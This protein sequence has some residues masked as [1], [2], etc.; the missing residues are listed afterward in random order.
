MMFPLFTVM[1]LA[2]DRKQYLRD[3]LNSVLLQSIDKSSFEILLIT[4]FPI[5]EEVS[6]IPN[7]KHM[8][9]DK[10]ELEIKIAEGIKQCRGEIVCFLEDDDTWEEDKLET[11]RRIFTNNSEIGF[12][13]NNF[14]MIGEDGTPASRTTYDLVRRRM[15][16]V[17]SESTDKNRA[18]FG[19]IR[20]LIKTGVNFNLSSMAIRKSIIQEFSSYLCLLNGRNSNVDTFMFY[21]ALLSGKIVKADSQEL[22]KYRI[23]GQNISANFILAGIG[24][25]QLGYATLF[26]MIGTSDKNKHIRRS[27]ECMVSDLKFEMYS[28]N[29][30]RNRKLI[31]GEILNHMRYFS[32]YDMTYDLLLTVFGL[33]YLIS[34]S[35]GDILHSLP[36]EHV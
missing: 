11:L 23:H 5:D 15:N 30:T 36:N 25:E 6:R 32:R 7:L 10:K 3:A 8:M 13:H 18:T 1:V 26:D 21:A 34:P 22:T 9:T 4:N 12:Y 14:K 33:L 20:K 17:G 31:A 35:L 24:P 27:V 29:K 28:R 2:H 16:R 19:E